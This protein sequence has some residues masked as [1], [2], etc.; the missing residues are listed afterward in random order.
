MVGEA[1]SWPGGQ[2]RLST[3]FARTA[4]AA[5]VV[6]NDYDVDTIDDLVAALDETVSSGEPL[7]SPDARFDVGY[8]SVVAYIR[9]G[10]MICVEPS[11]HIIFA[12]GRPETTRQQ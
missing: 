9:R 11:H 1:A 12:I 4:S 2:G 8:Y 10:L 6:L 3:R 7:P 5:L